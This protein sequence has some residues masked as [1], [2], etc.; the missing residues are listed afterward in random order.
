MANGKHIP[1]LSRRAAGPLTPR[2]PI[3][4]TEKGIQI[5][6]EWETINIPRGAYYG[7]GNTPGQKV[8]GKVLTYKSDGGTDYSGVTCPLLEVE[9]TE[10]TFTVGKNGDD[11]LDVGEAVTL[12]AGQARLRRGLLAANPAVGDLIEIILTAPSGGSGVPK[13]FSIRIQRGA[14]IAD[15]PPF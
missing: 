13:E 6:T 12:T 5:M 2:N 15:E 11:P 8:L 7:S 9:L 4:L 1:V 14:A 10:A 3:A